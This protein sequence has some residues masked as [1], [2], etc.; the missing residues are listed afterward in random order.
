MFALTEQQVALL[1]NT[2]QMAMVALKI[3][4]EASKP[5]VWRDNMDLASKA[6][7]SFPPE[8]WRDTHNALSD[9]AETFRDESLTSIPAPKANDFR[10]N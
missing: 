4:P 9:V 6:L 1:F 5:E 2:L 8:I 10:R 3:H 7:L